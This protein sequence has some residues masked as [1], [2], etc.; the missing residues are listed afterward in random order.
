LG[1]PPNEYMKQYLLKQVSPFE[2]CDFLNSCKIPFDFMDTSGLVDTGWC[3]Y[4]TNARILS[5]NDRILFTTES[6]EQA[7]VLVLKFG[8]RLLE[9]IP[10][11]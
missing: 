8:D 11:D 3:D 7:T 6:E 10:V 4:A 1:A 5:V 2:D 9:I